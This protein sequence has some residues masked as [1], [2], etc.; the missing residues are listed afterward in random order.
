MLIKGITVVSSRY[1]QEQDQGF[2]LLVDVKDPIVTTLTGSFM[3]I[4]NQN[5]D[6]VVLWLLHSLN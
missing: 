5:L 3:H 4:S 1:I 6:D 2:C